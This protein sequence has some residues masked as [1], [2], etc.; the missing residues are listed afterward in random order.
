M[1][2][3][4][5]KSEKNSKREKRISTHWHVDPPFYEKLKSYQNQGKNIENEQR[6][7]RHRSVIAEDKYESLARFC[8]AGEFNEQVLGQ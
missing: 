4:G 5:A 1:S 2:A 6:S 7:Q 8:L 3:Q